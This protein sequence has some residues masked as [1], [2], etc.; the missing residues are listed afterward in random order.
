MCVFPLHTLSKIFNLL[1]TS[2]KT[3]ATLIT[4]SIRK[5]RPLRLIAVRVF[6]LYAL[7]SGRKTP[8]PALTLTIRKNYLQALCRYVFRPCTVKNLYLYSVQKSST[9]L[10]IFLLQ[11]KLTK[12]SYYKLSVLNQEKNATFGSCRVCFSPS[13]TVK[14]L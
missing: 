5:K 7:S 9:L 3:A 12:T 2:S 11:S 14:N 13:H 10:K 1:F 8:Q 4:V 6:S